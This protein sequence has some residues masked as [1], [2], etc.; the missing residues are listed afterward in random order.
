MLAQSCEGF[1]FWAAEEEG[2]GRKGSQ[3]NPI[4]N[5]RIKQSGGRY[6][7]DLLID[8]KDQMINMVNDVGQMRIKMKGMP[9]RKFDA[10]RVVIVLCLSI[11]L[12]IVSVMAMKNWGSR[13]GEHLVFSGMYFGFKVLTT[14]KKAWVWIWSL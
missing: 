6:G 7:D 2:K 4:D 10:S 1:P 5:V 8:L 13:I 3:H 11:F 12:I 9:D 14:S